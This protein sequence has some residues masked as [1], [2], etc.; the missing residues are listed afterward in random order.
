MQHADDRDDRDDAA[1]QAPEA[2]RAGGD[3]STDSA[4]GADGADSADASAADAAE[5]APIVDARRARLRELG[6][7]VGVI[8]AGG[9]VLALS[10]T[11]VPEAGGDM[12]GPRWWP[13]VLSIALVVLGVALIGVAFTKAD[14]AR[15]DSPTKLGVIRLLLLFALIA[16]YGAAWYFVH[17]VA[18]TLVLAC[19]LTFVLG[20]RGW[21][22]LILFPVIATAVLYG[23]FGLLLGVPL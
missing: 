13:T 14:T 5:P 12:F 2:A 6:V 9:A 23:V 17:F 1:D 15:E 16:A 10:A 3:L 19:A 4:P 11:T 8:A 22:D 21:R 7:A 18:V 20:G